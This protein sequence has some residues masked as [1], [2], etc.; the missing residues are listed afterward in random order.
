MP[1][2]HVHDRITLITAGLLTPVFLAIPSDNRWISWGVLEGSYL[3]SGLLFS[4]DL[5]VMATEYR[6]WGPLRWL[7]LPYAQMVLHRSWLSHGL[8]VGPL[9]RL[10]YFVLVVDLLVVL[11][12]TAAG[13]GGVGGWEWIGRWH[14]F[15]ADLVREHPRHFVEAA[16]GFVLGGAAHSIPDWISTGIR[17][18][19]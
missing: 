18:L 16:V 13:V 5:D 4:N 12:A 6:R 9:L 7:W 11:G 19:V 1:Q 14:K 3:L 15:W 2:T 10:L 17:R 8:M